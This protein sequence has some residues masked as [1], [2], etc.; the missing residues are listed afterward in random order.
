MTDYK[1]YYLVPV[2]DMNS[3]KHLVGEDTR[4]SMDYLPDVPVEKRALVGTMLEILD[5][6][7]IYMTKSGELVVDDKR[8]DGSDFGV[9]VKYLSKRY[10]TKD[11]APIGVPE[12][13]AYLRKI[14]YPPAK[15]LNP[16]VRKQ[17]AT[18]DTKE[19][20]EPGWI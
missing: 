5:K 13:V 6:S 19:V 16:V 3:Q 11:A 8:V 17:L 18:L 9:I 20:T 7:G 12:L 15:V 14:N 4:R 10:P 1:K 2:Q